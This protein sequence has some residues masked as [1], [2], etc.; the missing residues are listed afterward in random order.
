[1][2]STTRTPL[3]N[4]RVDCT[5]YVRDDGLWEVEAHLVDSKPYPY[6]D[7][8]RGP[9]Q[10]GDAVHDIAVRLAVDDDMVI[11]EAEATMADIPYA[12]CLDVP[13]R[14][15]RL[16]GERITAGWRERVRAHLGRRDTCTHLNELLGPAITTLYQ[17]IVCGKSPA[18][19]NSIRDDQESGE[20]PIYLDGC[21]T[22]R[23]DGPTVADIFPNFAK[24]AVKQD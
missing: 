13:P 6:I 11:R 21:Y 20:R 24:T 4:R 22:W 14:L 17:A 12:T 18:G 7:F 16:V 3:H 9:R 1:M 2:P 19:G 10:P 23:S 15:E 5:S 8:R